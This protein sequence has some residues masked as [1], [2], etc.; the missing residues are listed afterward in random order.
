MPN[1]LNMKKLINT[2]FF[3]PFLIYLNAQCDPPLVMTDLNVN[4]VKARLL[5]GGDL[6][7]DRDN[8]GY[9]TPKNHPDNVA[10]IFTGGL[11]IGGLDPG[12]NLKV[13]A[14]TYG[15]ANGN[16]NYWPGPLDEET[17]NTS[18]DNCANFDRFWKIKKTDIEAHIADYEDDGIINNPIPPAIQAWPAKGNPLF[19]LQNGFQMPFQELA[20]Y[21]D[22]HGNGNYNPY[23]GDY[24]KIKGD[25]AIFWVINDMGDGN[26]SANGFQPVQM[27]IQ[28]MAYACS[29][30]GSALDNTTFY[31]FSYVNRAQEP[32]FDFMATLWVDPD[33]GCY[34]D[35]F[36]GSSP[37]H[38]MA[39]IYNEDAVD[40]STGTVCFGDIPTYGQNI[41]I[42]GI[43]VMDS[44]PNHLGEDVGFSSFTYWMSIPLGQPPLGLVGP[45][46]AQEFYNY[47]TGFARD[48]TPFTEGGDGY[49]LNSTDTIQHVFSGNPS[50]PWSWSLCNASGISASRL[51]MLNSGPYNLNP[52]EKITITY[53]V[54][55][56]LSADYPCPSFEIIT[57]MGEEIANECE[58]FT[59]VSDVNLN[60][61]DISVF[62][63][64]MNNFTE[65][66]SKNSNNPL[67]EIILTN[68]SGKTVRTF[69]NLNS[70]RFL[71]EKKDLTS[72]IYFLKIVTKR[73]LPKT[74]KLIILDFK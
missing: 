70:N 2:L 67:T 16:Y 59:D 58:G 1:C 24:P 33:L 55:T 65:I 69:S 13:S 42:V 9:F 61:S 62:P 18:A 72:G 35:D 40:G 54:I 46:S 39:I 17:G 5:T 68:A 71:L 29:E 7:W 28:A 25:E 66:V 31:E 43:K 41:P 10:A 50:D 27:E 22:R 6:W 56:Q 64:P 45:G 4:N 44:T 26:V 60:P 51:M 30:P 49:N 73:N 14:Q 37:E 47:M 63:N 21:V 34:S 23:H 11:F 15:A 12:G 38:K 20:P 19:V 32:I 57:Q 3:L 36:I 8:A 48:G 52:G 53:A 74:E